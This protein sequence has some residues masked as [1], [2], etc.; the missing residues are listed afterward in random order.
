M[1]SSGLSQD[2]IK[3]IIGWVALNNR[4]L[5]LPVLEAEKPK[6]KVPDNWVPV[7]FP[8]LADV[9]FLTVFLVGRKRKIVLVSLPLLI[10]T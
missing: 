3:N 5:F 9:C 10:R 6:I 8:G 7:G 4:H 2:S 1:N